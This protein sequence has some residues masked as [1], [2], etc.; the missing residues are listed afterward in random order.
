MEPM[1][2]PQLSRLLREW[3]VE[4]P[5]PALDVRVLGI[6]PSHQRFP[7][8]RW[9]RAIAAGTR[10]KSLWAAAVCGIA[11]LTVVTQAIPQ[12]L[13][14][15]SPP[16][17]VPYTVDSE[18]IQHADDGSRT[19]AM[20]STSYTDQNGA[21]VILERTMPDHPL[22]TAAGRTLDAILPLWGRLILPLT[23]SSEDLE[24]YK[25][26]ARPKTVGVVSGCGDKACLLVEHWYF[27][28]AESGPNFPCA[29]GAPAGHETILGYSTNAVVRPMPN[30]R[31]TPSQPSAARIT[32]WMAP[33]LGCL[34]LKLSIEE[35]R[36][37]SVFR[38][39]SEKKALRVNVKP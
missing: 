16:V 5:P 9:M 29:A 20:I 33:E 24:R 22:G 34:A 23:V 3:K 1:K 35:Q 4:D 28:K 11:F 21:E 12:T 32:L 39:V 19:V 27:A 18:Y 8:T 10:G 13:K 38:L 6:R 25:Q 15:V 7:A 17:H 36:P 26:S 30:P 31:A 14:L 37:D 2:D